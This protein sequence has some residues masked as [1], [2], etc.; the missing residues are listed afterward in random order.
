[1]PLLKTLAD[2]PLYK[3]AVGALDGTPISGFADG[4][5]ALRIASALFAGSDDEADFREA[6]PYLAKIEY[7][8]VGSGAADGLITAKLIAGVGE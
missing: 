7:L 8:A 2:T 1:M 3:E 4:P 6:E 5:A